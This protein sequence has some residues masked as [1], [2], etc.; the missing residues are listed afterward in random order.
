MER[1]WWWT[2]RTRKLKEK[3]RDEPGGGG[4][5]KGTVGKSLPLPE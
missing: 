1:G 5:E 4:E 2:G 3:G